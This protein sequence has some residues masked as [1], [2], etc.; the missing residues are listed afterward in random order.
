MEVGRFLWPELVLHGGRVPDEPGLLGGA[1]GIMLL[2][3]HGQGLGQEPEGHGGHE[4]DGPGNE[5]A[6]PPSADPPGV[7]R[8]DGDTLCR[9]GGG[10]LQ[11][12]NSTPLLPHPNTYTIPIYT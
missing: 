12:R 8:G 7:A 3:G 6:Q 4:G 5:V 1:A 2:Q 9:R 11:L 10:G